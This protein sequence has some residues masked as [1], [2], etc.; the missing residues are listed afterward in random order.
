MLIPSFMGEKL[1]NFITAPMLAI[2]LTL[3]IT[4]C[5]SAS[6]S[7]PSAVDVAVQKVCVKMGNQGFRIDLY[8]MFTADNFASWQE[9]LE[10]EDATEFSKLV[11]P[12]VSAQA[13]IYMREYGSAL[14]LGKAK[15]WD[16]PELEA[17]QMRC[18]TLG[19][20]VTL[21]ENLSQSVN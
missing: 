1:K 18:S 8:G 12:I 11:R 16:F 19:F 15:A 13:D 21:P 6:T 3:S 4:G 2:A 17:L 10:G 20:P 9:G 7:A 5:S 14:V